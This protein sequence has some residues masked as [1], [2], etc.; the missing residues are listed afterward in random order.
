MPAPPAPAALTLS[1]RELARA[2]LLALVGAA[3]LFV[4][5]VLPAEYNIDLTGFGGAIGLTALSDPAVTEG[6]T[7]E[8]DGPDAV[9][10]G[11]REDRVEVEVPPG[12]GVEYKFHLRAG[13]KMVY[14]WVSDP[15]SLFYDFHGEPTGREDGYF[16]SYV[17][18]TGES[19]RGT[20][21][22]P[23]DGSHGWYWKNP[24]VVT[25][26]VTLTT[27]GVYEVLGQP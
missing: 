15:G 16:E 27:S 12:E 19:S 7:G 6:A 2:V 21:T 8:G 26:H 18:T 17:V 9:A 1:S 20:F 24:S 23:F 4:L 5:V 10:P 14:E 3:V 25:V 11:A 22:A 13:D